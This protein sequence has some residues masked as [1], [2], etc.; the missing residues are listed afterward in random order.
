M[1]LKCVAVMGWP[2]SGRSIASGVV[3]NGVR[4]SNGEPRKIF[5]SL[6]RFSGPAANQKTGKS[7]TGNDVPGKLCR[8][9]VSLPS[10]LAYISGPV[11]FFFSFFFPKFKSCKLFGIEV[12]WHLL[13]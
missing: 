10:E 12:S 6:G 8:N 1:A 3:F 13:I 9:L 11:S 5:V 4:N 2:D 7:S